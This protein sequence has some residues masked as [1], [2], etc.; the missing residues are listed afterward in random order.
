ME[1]ASIAGGRLITGAVGRNR[2]GD[3]LITKRTNSLISNNSQSLTAVVS[4][5]S[6]HQLVCPDC[7]LLQLFGRQCAAS[8]PPPRDVNTHGF[9]S[10]Q[11]L[12]YLHLNLS[13]L[14]SIPAVCPLIAE[15]LPSQEIPKPAQ[16]LYCLPR[17]MPMFPA[18]RGALC[19]ARLS[20]RPG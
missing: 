3:L 19:L 5:L 20:S 16:V 8:V 14:S 18:V 17:A 7:G 6:S 4:S 10:L 1:T 9:T 13:V 12:L 11:R 15:V 2:T